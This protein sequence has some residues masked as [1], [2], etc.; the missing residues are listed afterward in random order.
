MDQEHISVEDSNPSKHKSQTDSLDK[1]DTLTVL[2]DDEDDEDMY[3][4]DDD[5]ESGDWYPDYDN[6]RQKVSADDLWAP[7]TTWIILLDRPL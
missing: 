7:S 1:L 5:E 6:R 4:S 3:D 2:E